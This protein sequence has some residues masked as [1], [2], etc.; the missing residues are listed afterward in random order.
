[1][2]AAALATHNGEL[3][4]NQVLTVSDE[5][6]V[7]LSKHKGGLRLQNLE[8]ISIEAAN[9]LAGIEGPL[10]LQLEYITPDS[11]AEILRKHPSFADED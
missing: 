8:N 4:L 6:S 1:M 3:L 5:V 10:E 2:V 7:E 11:S 9:H